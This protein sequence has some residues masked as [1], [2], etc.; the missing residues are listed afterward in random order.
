FWVGIE[1]GIE[2]MNDEMQAF[3]WVAIKSKIKTGKSK[4]GTFF[5]PVRIVKLI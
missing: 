4:T 1:G 2:K 3:A 5:L